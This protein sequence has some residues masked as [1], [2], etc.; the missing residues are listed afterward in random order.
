[1]NS[2]A[3]MSKAGGDA[4]GEEAQGPI[5]KILTEEVSKQREGPDSSKR[6]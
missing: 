2:S 4:L 3:R 1:M 5:R 6:G